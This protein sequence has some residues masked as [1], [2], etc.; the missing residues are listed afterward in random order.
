VS[1]N[2]DW[3]FTKSVGSS[4]IFLEYGMRHLLTGHTIYYNY[5]H[6]R[7]GQLFQKRILGVIDF[8]SA[9]LKQAGEQFTRG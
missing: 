5:R 4:G 1:W 9:L 7:Q 8:E 3:I 2:A 6:H